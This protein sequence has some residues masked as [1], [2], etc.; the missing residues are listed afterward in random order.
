MKKRNDM[1]LLTLIR[2]AKSDWRDCSVPD[3]KRPL[4]PRGLNDAPLMGNII[5]ERGFRFDRMYT[6]PAK[7]CRDTASL[8]A[9]NAELP[10]KQIKEE[11]GLYT[12]DQNDLY[13]RVLG[14]HNKHRSIALVAHNPAITD[15]LNRLCDENIPNMPTCAV[16]VIRL[17]TRFWAELPYCTKEIAYYDYPKNY[18]FLVG[19]ENGDSYQANLHQIQ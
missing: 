9:E 12:F 10:I 11:K 13:E 8:I 18:R 19:R 14:F 2:H 1:K 17:D 5:R 16:A 7:R 4:N 6:S 15:L 3:I